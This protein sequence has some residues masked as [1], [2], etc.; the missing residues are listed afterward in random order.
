MEIFMRYKKSTLH[1]HVFVECDE[2]GEEVESKDCKIPM[3]YI[4]KIAIKEPMQ[5]ITVTVEKGI[6]VDTDA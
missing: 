5:F 3:L 6:Q 2:M 1:T 4:R